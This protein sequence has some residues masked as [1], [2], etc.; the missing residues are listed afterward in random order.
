MC[1][2]NAQL[3]QIYRSLALPFQVS[4]RISWLLGIVMRG[5]VRHTC[6]YPARTECGRL[7]LVCGLIALLSGQAARGGGGAATRDT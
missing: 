3:R 2:P 5:I 6:R 7:Q 1:P 4:N